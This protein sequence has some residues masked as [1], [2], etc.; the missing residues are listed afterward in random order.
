MMIASFLFKICWQVLLYISTLP[1]F[2]NIA[3][4]ASEVFE[5]HMEELRAKQ[6]EISKRESDIK[7]LE[8]IIQTLG[9]KE[10]RSTSG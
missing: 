9:G 8:A 6:E 1:K 5:L 3:L 2:Y 4:F 7:L 10:S